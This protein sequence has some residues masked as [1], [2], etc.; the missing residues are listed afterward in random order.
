MSWLDI[1]ILLPLL[2]GLV[3]GLMRGLIIE[4]T[5][6]VSII[7]GFIG[8]KTWGA[9]FSVWLSQ[10]F[11]WPEAVCVVVAYALLFL[12]ITLLLNIIAKLL[13]KLFKTVNL[14]WINR[15]FGGIFG[16]AKWAAIV[17]LVVLC[18]HRLDD[19]F[20]FLKT[21]LKQQ[22]TIYSYVTPLSE[23]A[24]TKVKQQVTTYSSKTNNQIVKE[25]QTENE[26]E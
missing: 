4:L 17:L 13:S 5:A 3:R 9:P 11:D 21:E 18:I 20:H 26:Q 25:N 8:T 23:K 7:I 6:I 15:I 19:Q 22:S 16:V 10:Q 14:G 2:I 1:L 24:W 12:G